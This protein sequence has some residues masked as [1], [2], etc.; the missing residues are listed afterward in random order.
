MNNR[1]IISFI[2]SLLLVQSGVGVAGAINGAVNTTDEAKNTSALIKVEAKAIAD[3]AKAV[4]NVAQAEAALAKAEAEVAKLEAA[5]AAAQA[6]AVAAQ[7]A[8]DQ[9]ENKAQAAETAEAAAKVEVAAAK[10]AVEK[11]RHA[12]AMAAEAAAVQAREA[13]AEAAADAAAAASAAVKVVEENEARTDEAIAAAEAAA[14]RAYAIADAKAA[15][16]E[17]RANEAAIAVEMAE[18]R[19]AAAEEKVESSA[20]V[21]E[22]A[23]DAK[24]AV[25]DA[26]LELADAKAALNLAETDLVESK[27]ALIEAKKQL[28][29]VKRSRFFAAASQY[30]SWR[31][32]HG[33][34]G[35]QFYQPYDFSY[36]N[37]SME[38][39][40]STAYIISE[41]KPAADGRVATWTDT[42][43][44]IAH[45]NLNKKYLVR[46]SLAINLPTGKSK[47]NGTNAIMS[48]DLVRMS[49]FG[50]GWN[51]TPGVSI[52]RKIGEE[53]TW[54]IE[55][56]YSF[57]GSYTY[58]GSITN[59]QINPGNEW[60]KTLR[61]QHAGQK[62]QLA[63]ELTH[64]SFGT[65]KE[66]SIDYREG[67]Q[68]DVKMTYNR[69]LAQD[70]NLMLYYWHSTAKP[71][72]SSDPAAAGIEGTSTLYTKYFGAVWSK[73]RTEKQTFRVMT[74][75]MYSS[76]SSYDPL[77]NLIINGRTKYSGGFGYDIDFTPERRLSL[78]IEKYYMKDESPGN[79]YHGYNYY[80]RY[81]VS[82]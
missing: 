29:P 67:D 23:N 19:L 35:Y 42:T 63:G 68:F 64:T 2:C 15:A 25:I 48:E 30:Y 18:A 44:S 52:S 47:L 70:Q 8:A 22:E 9:A 71:Y 27:A 38:Y 24:A 26:Q 10:A 76:G 37:N 66:N 41:N 28:E 78:D 79:S 32:N 17:E 4:A 50:E 81:Y 55:N 75:I 13:E 6:S 61:W 43:L 72:A 34:S 73:A 58:D 77:T 40:L 45:N 21:R 33:R 54:T 3:H 80:L 16:A 5:E 74:D 12:E 53:D 11:A 60:T 14:D 69:K 51:Y 7:L 39:G 65:T 57:R 56:Y 20:G 31:D 59:G 62:Y 49:R 46:C 36:A 1:K 82:M